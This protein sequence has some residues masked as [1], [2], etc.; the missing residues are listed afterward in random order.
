MGV[1][2]TILAVV[3][4][5]SVAWLPAASGA[6]V[7]LK[8]TDMTDMSVSEAMDDCCPPHVNPCDKAMGDCGSMAA[9]TLNCLSYVGAIS[10]PLVYP[11][12]LAALMPLFESA[13]LHSHTGSPPFRPPRV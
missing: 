1:C 6:S 7:K 3:V 4:A 13:D 11:V 2:Q 9:C 12:T 8:S 5:V 10:S